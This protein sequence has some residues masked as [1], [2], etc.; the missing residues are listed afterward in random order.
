M[1]KREREREYVLQEVSET[2]FKELHFIRKVDKFRTRIF[3]RKKMDS[4][5]KVSRKDVSD[6]LLLSTDL[7]IFYKYK[8]LFQSSKK[9]QPH[10]LV[11]ALKLIFSLKC[12]IL[13]KK[14]RT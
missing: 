3:K 11:K 5:A 6:I 9:Q 14:S 10:K 12:S 2:S 1:Q 4:L 7:Y 8:L 13:K